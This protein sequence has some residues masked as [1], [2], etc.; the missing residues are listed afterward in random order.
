M[1]HELRGK[2]G[3]VVPCGQVLRPPHGVHHQQTDGHER[4]YNDREYFFVKIASQISRHAR[5]S[6]NKVYIRKVVI[7]QTRDS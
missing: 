3:L 7:T 6:G 2:E 1:R 4:T 5:T